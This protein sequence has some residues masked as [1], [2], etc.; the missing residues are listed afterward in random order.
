[1]EKVLVVDWFSC[2]FQSIYLG[3][4]LLEEKEMLDN[5]VY[6]DNVVIMFID[7][8]VISCM[9]EVMVIIYGNLLSIYVEGWKVC[10]LI[11]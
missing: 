7:I 3:S 1:M 5:R 8:V 10:I 4:K 6:L 2:D 9:V 11:E